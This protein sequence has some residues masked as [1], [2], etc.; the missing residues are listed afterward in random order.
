M[1]YLAFQ[2]MKK[3]K[4][5]DTMETVSHYKVTCKLGFVIY[6]WLAFHTLN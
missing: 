2:S 4:V 1:I 5:W 3:S 6:S